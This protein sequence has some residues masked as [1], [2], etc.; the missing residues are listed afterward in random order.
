MRLVSWFPSC[1]FCDAVMDTRS[2]T[3]PSWHAW[4]SWARMH[5]PWGG[6][7]VAAGS[8]RSFY[9]K[10][11]IL[12]ILNFLLERDRRGAREKRKL[13]CDIILIHFMVTPPQSHVKWWLHLWR[14]RFGRHLRGKTSVFTDRRTLQHFLGP[15]MTWCLMAH[16]SQSQGPHHSTPY[17]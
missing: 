4:E 10:I 15:H 11:F 6:G 16:V 7:G 17:Q 12:A 8:H 1:S 3:G 14:S 2:Q 5:F 13:C 9:E